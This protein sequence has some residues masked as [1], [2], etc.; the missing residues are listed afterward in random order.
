[1]NI[2]GREIG[3]FGEID[4]SISSVF[5]LRVPVHAGEFDVHALTELLP[6][7]LA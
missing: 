5:G 6:D 3:S 4:P 2:G 1:V 7:P